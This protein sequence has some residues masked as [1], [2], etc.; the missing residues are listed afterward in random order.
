MG[1]N[2]GPGAGFAQS[3]GVGANTPPPYTPP[4]QQ[5]RQGR[6]GGRR[7][8]SQSKGINTGPSKPPTTASL[9]GGIGLPGFGGGA[10]TY[11][12]LYSPFVNMGS[13]QDGRAIPNP[14]PY[15][16]PPGFMSQTNPQNWGNSINTGPSQMP[17]MMNGS[18]YMAGGGFTGNRMP[19]PPPYNDPGQANIPNMTPGGGGMFGGGSFG[20]PSSRFGGGMGR[21]GRTGRD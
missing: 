5:G 8:R 9:G 12:N 21:F 14:D 15:G 13:V 10:R 17:P 19:P 2:V 4:P 7:G 16:M 11:Q 6:Q 1:L 3:F 18:P 20:S